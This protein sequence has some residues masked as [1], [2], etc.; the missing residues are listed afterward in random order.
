MKRTARTRGIACCMWSL[1]RCVLVGRCLSLRLS[2]RLLVV[3]PFVV[4]MLFFQ[5]IT[6]NNMEALESNVLSA[7]CKYSSCAIVQESSVFPVLFYSVKN[8]AL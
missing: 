2:V 4:I 5:S 8:T 1:Q 3:F 6:S 7:L